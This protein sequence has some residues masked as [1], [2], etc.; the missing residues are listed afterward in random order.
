MDTISILRPDELPFSVPEDLAIS[1]NGFIDSL[2]NNNTEFIDCW[3]DEIEGGARMLPADQD[4]WIRNYYVHG[5][6]E[7]EDTD[8]TS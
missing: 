1:I 6:W 8:R 5:A 4:N 7:D 2:K 3:L